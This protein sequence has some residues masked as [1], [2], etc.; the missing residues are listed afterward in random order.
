[1]KCGHGTIRRRR[2]SLTSKACC[3]IIGLRKCR[4]V[5]IQGERRSVRGIR[6]ARSTSLSIDVCLPALPLYFSH[7]P[8]QGKSLDE[9]KPKSIVASL[10]GSLPSRYRNVTVAQTQ[11]ITQGQPMLTGISKKIKLAANLARIVIACLFA[12]AIQ[13]SVQGR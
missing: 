3:L 5:L 1:M 10:T 2:I 13:L 9:F 7:L 4:S 12:T 11:L 8:S 6:A